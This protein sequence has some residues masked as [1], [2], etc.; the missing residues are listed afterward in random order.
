MSADNLIYMQKRGLRWWVWMGDMSS[1]RK[2]KPPRFGAYVQ[3]FMT[4]RDAL[5]YARRLLREEVIEYGLQIL[6]DV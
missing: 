5:A 1:P 6:E 2:P 4:E 3:D